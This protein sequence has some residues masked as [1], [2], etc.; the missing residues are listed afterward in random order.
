MQPLTI[1]RTINAPVDKVWSAI[2]DHSEMKKWYFDI[3]AFEPVAGFEFS[4]PGQGHKGAQYIHRC[5]VLE[6]IPGRKISY[7]WRYEDYPGNSIVTFEL[8]P[9]GDKTIVKLTHTGLETFPAGNPD[10]A[11]SSFEG[12]WTEI[13]GNMLPKYLGQ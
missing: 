2:T 12:G 6:V 4:F 1:E 9:A 8:Q 11:R 3:D 7:S 13:L 5:K 10:F